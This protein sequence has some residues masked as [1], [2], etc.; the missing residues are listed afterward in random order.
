[1]AG[2]YQWGNQL[3]EIPRSCTHI[4]DIHPRRETQ[5]LHQQIRTLFR[6]PIGPF[7]PGRALETHYVRNF[8][9]KIELADAVA[10]RC[11]RLIDG[12]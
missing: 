1:L 10:T 9:M 6:L 7:K 3:R 11:P 4:G 8:A 2:R 12:R 5:G